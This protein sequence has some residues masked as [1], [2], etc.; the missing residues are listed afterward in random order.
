[1]CIEHLKVSDY[2]HLKVWERFET[3]DIDLDH[4]SQICHESL[5]VC[6]IPCECDY[7][8]TTLNLPFK[9]ELCFDHLHHTWDVQDEFETVH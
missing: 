4:Q 1:M 6:V 8:R 5:N 7:F 2:Y 3:S 9:L